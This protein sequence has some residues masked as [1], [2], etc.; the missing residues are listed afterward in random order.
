MAPKRGRFRLFWDD[1][2]QF[3]QAIHSSRVRQEYPLHNVDGEKRSTK[4]ELLTNKTILELCAALRELGYLSILPLST[5][6]VNC[7]S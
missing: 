7:F 2:R 3:F 6:L 4:Q 1:G 5:P